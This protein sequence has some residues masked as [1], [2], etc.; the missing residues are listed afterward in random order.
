M[1]Y[2]YP[3]DHIHID[4]IPFYPVVISIYDIFS[5]PGSSKFYPLYFCFRL[6]YRQLLAVINRPYTIY[7]FGVN[8]PE[9]ASE[10]QVRFMLHE[11]FRA[12]RN[13]TCCVPANTDLPAANVAPLL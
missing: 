7:D 2:N 4:H 6:L 13:T 5:V 11:S 8:R 3:T 10:R 12:A 1:Q 9:P